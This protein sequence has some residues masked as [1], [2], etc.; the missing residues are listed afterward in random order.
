MVGDDV[1][2]IV[3]GVEG[4]SVRIGI[5]APKQIQIYRSEVYEMIQ[6]SNK[7]ATKSVI[8][9][10]QLSLWVKKANENKGNNG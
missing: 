3:L 4:D 6:E 1:E 7:E 2:V 8:N 9:M 5:Q 10:E